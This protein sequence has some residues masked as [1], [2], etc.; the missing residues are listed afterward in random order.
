[1]LDDL[2]LLVEFGAGFKDLAVGSNFEERSV[3][4]HSVDFG[5]LAVASDF[6]GSAVVSDFGSLAV[7]SDFKGL[8]G[9]SDSGVWARLLGTWRLSMIPLERVVSWISSQAYLYLCKKATKKRA[10][11]IASY[12][13]TRV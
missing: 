5:D 11:I 2:S 9:E 12:R 8:E 1:M 7:V 3:S 10:Y 6:G 4:G 13:R